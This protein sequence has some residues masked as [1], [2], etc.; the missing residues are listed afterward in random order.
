MVIKNNLLP[1]KIPSK[2]QNLLLRFISP[3][4][5]GLF[6][7][8]L[9]CIKLLSGCG[10]QSVQ[11]SFVVSDD[12]AKYWKPLIEQFESKY[13]DINIELANDRLPM[14][15]SNSEQ[16]KEIYVDAFNKGQPYDLIYMDIIWVPEFAEKG[17]L[18]NLSD[19]F[20]I[21][22][23]KKEFLHSELDNGLYKNQLYRIPFRTD[24]GV[25]FYN[26]KHLNSVKKK[27]PETFEDLI[28][29]S[30]EVEKKFP[31]VQ[32]YLWQGQKTEG[33]IAMFLEV[34]KG[35]GGFW[36]N[37]EKQVGLN[38]EKAIQ[39]VQFLHDTI[40][41]YKISPSA[42]IRQNEEK[43]RDTFIED[44]AV[45][46]RNWPYVWAKAN[47]P[48]SPVRGNIGIIPMVHAVGEKSSASKGG[49]GFGIAKNSIHH[50]QAKQAIEFFINA[51]SQWQFTLEYGSVPSRRQLF[52]EPKIVNKYSHY[53]QLLNIMDDPDIWYK[54]PNIPEYAKASC[55]LQK[56][57][58]QALSTENGYPT[59]R[60]AMN[61]A[62]NETELLLT[63]GEFSCE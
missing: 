16:L 28:N 46:M 50:K 8:F 29:I 51:A 32:G 25:L 20:P 35:Y 6:F 24:V 12:E 38:Q 13:P 59:P 48:D 52:F 40:Y 56:Y 43:T 37:D 44:K 15:P 62:A 36:I 3:R 21:E 17:W 5:L 45:F 54:R 23:L 11:L 61:Q 1:T 2:L 31:N 39:A 19:Q 55:I 34:L 49:W 60:K 30:M 7:V 4:I 47:H 10:N 18:L 14:K 53:P 41:K 22:D 58:H 42:I 9:L 57:L 26:K 33:M 63:K 27:P